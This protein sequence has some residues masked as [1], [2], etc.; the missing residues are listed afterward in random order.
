MEKIA[1]AADVKDFL[2]PRAKQNWKMRA[3]QNWKMGKAATKTRT[4]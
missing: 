2:A 4:V 3:K 1:R